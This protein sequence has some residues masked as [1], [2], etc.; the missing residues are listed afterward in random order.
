MATARPRKTAPAKAAPA[1]A[2]AAKTSCVATVVSDPFVYGALVML[3][4]F[5]RENPWFAGD[6]VI[7]HD[8]T[9]SPLSAKNRELIARIAPEARFQAVDIRRFERVFRFA[10]DVVRTP[11]RL[12]AAFLILECFTFSQ[13][14]R[15]LTLDS[16]MVILGSL[17]FLFELEQEFCVVRAHDSVLDLPL[18]FFNTGTM[19][20]R[21]SMLDAGMLETI[22]HSLEGVTV[23][24]DHGKADQAVLNVFFRDRPKTYLDGRYN[25]SKRLVPTGE[26]D[27]LKFLRDKDV[28]VL[29]F[30]GEKP[31]N[32]KIKDHER[33]YRRL[34]DLWL[35]YFFSVAPA[36]A[37]FRFTRE[38]L[39]QEKMIRDYLIGSHA[40]EKS[41]KALWRELEEQ[42]AKRLYDGPS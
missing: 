29:H 27:V 35:K 33:D 30:L 31:W 22:S 9:T 23:S 6:L 14:E 7:L 12:R 24:R 17:R 3:A 11:E 41:K 39:Y 32:L 8:D 25:F 36:T 10:E 26:P 37:R 15:V 34:E 28:R 42:L 20:I 19:M 1:K 40:T 4:S 13:Y 18:P 5:R 2:V 16:D 38:L 21:G